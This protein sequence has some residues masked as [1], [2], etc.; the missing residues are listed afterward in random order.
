MAKKDQEET[1]NA[2][3][4]KVL[5]IDLERL[6]WEYCSGQGRNDRDQMDED[7]RARRKL[8]D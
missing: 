2:A 7:A 3:I 4:H 5:G 8:K 1:R 6:A